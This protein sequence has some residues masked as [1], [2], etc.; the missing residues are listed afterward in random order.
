MVFDMYSFT[1][2]YVRD[3]QFDNIQTLAFWKNQYCLLYVDNSTVS[4]M[5]L[6]LLDWMP[7]TNSISKSMDKAALIDF[8]SANMSTSMTPYA[9][10]LGK[11]TSSLAESNA[12]S[13]AK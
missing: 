5:G 7:A 2:I 1:N 12:A 11:I 4:H 13:V 8:L 6:N 9:L 3:T 10:K